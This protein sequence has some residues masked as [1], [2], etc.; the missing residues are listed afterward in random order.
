[1]L[2]T[3]SLLQTTVCSCTLCRMQYDRLSQQQLS[4]LFSFTLRALH[5]TNEGHY[6]PVGNK[7]F[8]Q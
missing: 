8:W 1:M 7:T 5:F 3:A 4:F 2:T 6:G